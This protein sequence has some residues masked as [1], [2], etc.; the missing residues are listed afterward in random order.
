M[1]GFDSQQQNAT[2]IP[3]ILGHTPAGTSTQTLIHFGQ[4]I[5][6]G[7]FR[8]FDHGSIRNL[9]VYGSIFPTAYNLRGVRAAVTIHYGQNDWL[10]VE[11]DV[12]QLSR[13]LGNSQGAFVVSGF[14]HIDFL[15]GI[16][17]RRLVY[18]RVVA[19]MQRFE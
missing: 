5:R 10:S 3:V 16:D 19:A 17:A 7:R 14:N 4:L 12:Q 13:E 6:S 1:A 9:V 11:R 15:F 18:S 2:M 8:Q